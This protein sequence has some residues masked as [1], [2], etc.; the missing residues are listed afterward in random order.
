MENQAGPDEKIL[1]VQVDELR[2]F[3]HG[4]S[5]Y[6]DLPQILGDQ[7]AHLIAHYKDLERDKWSDIREWIDVDGS[8]GDYGRDRTSQDFQM[9]GCL[10]RQVPY[11]E[12][13]NSNR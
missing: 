1:A 2:P 13:L 6:R 9:K 3:Y 4:V 8:E 11:A 10:I 7:I 12:Q 5:S